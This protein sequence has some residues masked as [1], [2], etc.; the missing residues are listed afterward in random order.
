VSEV[1]G[2]A[3][4]DGERSCAS[5]IVWG[6]GGLPV[7]EEEYCT[8]S[9]ETCGDLSVRGGGSVSGKGSTYVDLSGRHGCP[10]VSDVVAE[11]LSNG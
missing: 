2:A 6:S 8:A 9:S 11:M 3:A 7:G 5:G 4:R 1:G 10:L